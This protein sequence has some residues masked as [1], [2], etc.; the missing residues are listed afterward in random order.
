MLKEWIS[1]DL[2]C[3]CKDSL[4]LRK[5][6]FNSENKIADVSQRI[7][8]R[9]KRLLL[10]IGGVFSGLECSHV[11]CAEIIPRDC[12]ERSAVI[13]CAES[14]EIVSYMGLDCLVSSRRVRLYPLL[15]S[16]AQNVSLSDVK[17]FHQKHLMRGYWRCQVELS[18]WVESAGMIVAKYVADD[19]GKAT[20]E[21]FEVYYRAADG[22]LDTLHLSSLSSLEILSNTR[23]GWALTEQKRLF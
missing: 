22:I 21:F 10:P 20:N 2:F 5:N 6:E 8:E 11:E 14:G 9:G 18:G 1:Y 12:Q 15:P 13:S 4:A 16:T 3:Q 7:I 23:S 17:A 19:D